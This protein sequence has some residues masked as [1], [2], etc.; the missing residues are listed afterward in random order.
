MVRTAIVPVGP[1]HAAFLEP[2]HLKLKVEEE[3]VVGAEMSFGYNHRGMEHALAQDFK[4]SQYLCERVCGIC[5]YHHASAY[6]QA[7]EDLYGLVVP[8]RAK[9]VRIIMME[10]QRLT[11][12]LL[13]LGHMAET[14]GYENL[15]MQ[16][17][18]EREEFMMLVNRVSGGRVH[19][20]MNTIGGLRKDVTPDQLKDIALTV[21]R[22]EPKLLDLQAIVRKD[23][24]M[25]KRLIGVGRL[26]K[27]DALDW[28][29]VGPTIRGSGL[30]DDVRSH[31]FSGYGLDG[32]DFK[33][34]V[35]QEGDCYARTMVRMDEVIQSLDLIRQALNLMK[36]GEVQT[37][38]KGNP[39]AKE[40]YG[41]VEAPRGELMYW[42]RGKNEVQL[43]RIKLRT[44]ALVNI[45]AVNAMI[46]GC[47][48]ADVPCI[49]VSVDP[50]ICCT[51]R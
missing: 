7:M 30:E 31:G 25:R 10:C 12:H 35:Y 4:R 32:V 51:D 48:V 36:E 2:F 43:D 44:P 45:P 26:T 6:C 8:D 39:P 46:R 38:F 9:F 17:F 11:S 19:Y 20:S 40:G 1:Q 21:D 3:T 29:A 14:I 24:T 49:T 23:P 47:R 13:A 33:P 50:C 42:V 34:I 37:K 27:E 15:F 28:C 16:F 5:S 41:R 18:R 22:L